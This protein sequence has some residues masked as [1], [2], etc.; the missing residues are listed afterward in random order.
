LVL[1]VLLVQRQA[2]AV[3]VL[4]ALQRLTPLAQEILYQ[5]RVALQVVGVVYNL[6]AF[7]FKELLAPLEVVDNLILQVVMELVA[8]PMTFQNFPLVEMAVIVFG[9]EAVE[10]A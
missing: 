6:S 9:A 2:V 10:V 4:V 3:E 8:L 5:P 1:V 7:K